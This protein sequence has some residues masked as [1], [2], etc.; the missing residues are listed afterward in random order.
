MSEGTRMAGA[1]CVL[2]ITDHSCTDWALVR[3]HAR[4][5]V[6]MRNALRAAPDGGAKVAKL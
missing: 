2:I 4:L 6:D 1:D 5:V 3:R